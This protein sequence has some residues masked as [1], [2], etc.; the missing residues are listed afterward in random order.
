MDGATGRPGDRFTAFW[1][2]KIRVSVVRFR[3]WPPSNQQVA[4]RTECSKERC[5]HFVSDFNIS[6]L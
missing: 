3:P 6:I 4:P 2:L 5:F 1:D